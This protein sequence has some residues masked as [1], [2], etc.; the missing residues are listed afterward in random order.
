MMMG[1]L[2]AA[3]FLKIRKKMIWFLIFLAPVGVVSLQAVNYGLRYDY[4]MKTTEADRW[5]GLLGGIHFLLTPALLLGIAIIASMVA[6]IEH[7]MNA[8][9]QLLALPI[10][11][12]SVYAAK[13]ALVAL[14][15]S[16]SCVL[17]GIGTVLLGTVLDLGDKVP[18]TEV[19][20]LALYPFAAS[21]PVLAL[22]LWLSLTIHNQA[23]PLTV[24]I[25]GSIVSMF[26]SPS[27][28]VVW[29][30]PTGKP[31]YSAGAGLAVG[32]GLLLLGMIDFTRRDVN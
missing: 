5:G 1:K 2:L 16:V 3:D 31:E 25:A 22:Q 8:W 30:W 21:L 4:L 14:L 6:N 13:F 18:L 7:Q 9:K 19:V 29:S 24:G 28:W 20:K 27:A 11:R 12:T 32:I 26:V 15:L 10:P 23:I 17:L